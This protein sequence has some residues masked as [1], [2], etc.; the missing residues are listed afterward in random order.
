MQ[1]AKLQKTVHQT[2]L[3]PA[4]AADQE[5]SHPGEDDQPG[6]PPPLPVL[7]GHPVPG[8]P[9]PLGAEHEHLHPGQDRLGLL[10]NYL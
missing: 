4:A 8:V 7:R 2:V 5:G 1:A 9:L 3:A 6:D 10:T